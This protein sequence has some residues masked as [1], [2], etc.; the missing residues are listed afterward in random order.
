MSKAF[1][2][3]QR[4]RPQPDLTLDCTLFLG[5]VLLAGVLLM[6]H[7]LPAKQATISVNSHTVAQK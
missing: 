5:L 2:I 6:W 1:L 7:T 4:P 3:G